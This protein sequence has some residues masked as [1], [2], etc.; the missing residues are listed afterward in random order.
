MVATLETILQSEQT[1]FYLLIYL[2]EMLFKI[3]LPF[4][5]MNLQVGTVTR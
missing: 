4:I 5:E 1:Q 2:N 3:L